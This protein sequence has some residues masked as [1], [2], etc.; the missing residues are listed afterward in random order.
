MTKQEALSLTA[1]SPSTIFTREDVQRLINAIDM[2]IPADTDSAPE[3]SMHCSCI[4]EGFAEPCKNYQ[5]PMQAD[6]STAGASLF[7]P[8]AKPLTDLDIADIA[9][10]IAA[11][12][13]Q[14]ESILDIDNAELSLDYNRTVQVDSCPIDEHEL[15]EQIS[16][17]LVKQLA[18]RGLYQDVV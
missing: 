1:G 8:D 7:A 13:A 2:Y 18:K 14:E 9:D 6:P 10:E 15:S 4:N 12:I 11:Y 3:P 17:Q 5:H 16:D